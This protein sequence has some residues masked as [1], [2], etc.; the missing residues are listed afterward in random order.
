M[1][2]S[3]TCPTLAQVVISRFVG[4]S[5]VSGSMLTAQSPELASDAVSPSLSAPPLI[6]LCLSL[7]QKEIINI[8]PEISLDVANGI[9]PLT[10]SAFI[11]FH[12][13]DYPGLADFSLVTQ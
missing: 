3:V 2:Q 10:Y 5:A 12:K 11:I 7:S 13:L 4:L 1:A 6:M 9:E 8:S